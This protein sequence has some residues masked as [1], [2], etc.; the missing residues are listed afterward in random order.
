MI[1]WCIILYNILAFDPI[2]QVQEGDLLFQDSDCGPFCVAIEKVTNGYEGANLS[3]IGMVIQSSDGSFQVIEAITDGVVITSMENFLQRSMDENGNP[4]VIVGR[5]KN[6]HKEIIPDA[7]HYAKRLLGKHYDTIFD[8]NNDQYYCS[9][10]IYESFKFANDGT[11][12]FHLYPMTFVDPDTKSSFDIWVDYYNK[13]GVEI[14][15]GELGLNPGGISLSDQI[16]IVH[17]Y[18]TPSGMIIK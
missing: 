12:I 3:H 2:F 15:E 17:T 8:I 5:L 11:P 14:P 1:Y 10:L 6:H 18:G 16:K 9:E 13:L 4:K 7:I